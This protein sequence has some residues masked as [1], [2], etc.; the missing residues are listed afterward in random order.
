MYH[1][2]IRI[3]RCLCQSSPSVSDVDLQLCFDTL[4]L[5][6][7]LLPNM[8]ANNGDILLVGTAGTIWIV[9]L[10]SYVYYEYEKEQEIKVAEAKRQK[11]V[12]K[13]KIKKISAKPVDIV[14]DE[15]SEQAIVMEKMELSNNDVVKVAKMTESTKEEVEKVPIVGDDDM[16]EAPSTEESV[17]ATR[18]ELEASEKVEITTQKSS[19]QSIPE[20]PNKKSNRQ[21]LQRFLFWRKKE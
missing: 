16:I 14:K 17:I 7:Y 9:Y 4:L 19:T 12:S 11:T 5:S 15:E 10:A 1:L 21:L 2:C 20:A 18:I 3:R 8:R 6:Q 13:A